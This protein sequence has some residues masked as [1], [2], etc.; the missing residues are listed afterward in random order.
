M[1]KPEAFFAI[2]VSMQDETRER[3]EPGQ[4]EPTSERK[5]RF[6]KRYKYAIIIFIAAILALGS[7]VAYV[8]A[9]SPEV[10]RSP[11]PEHYHFRMQIVVNGSEE[12]FGKDVYQTDYVKNQ[13]SADLPEQPIHFHD[14]KNQFVHIH[15]EGITGGMVM[16]NYGWNY[17]GGMSDALGYRLDDLSDVRKVTLHGDN[18]P[19]AP[20]DA[21]VYVYTGDEQGYEERS[22][23]D[24]K[25]KDL[26]DF[27]GKASNSPTNLLNQ[28][29]SF[30]IF[31]RI[32]PS[33]SAHGAAGGGHGEMDTESE[34]E[35]L[36]RINNLLGN[37][38]IFAQKDRPT[39]Q[40][41]KDRFASLEPLSDSTCGG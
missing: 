15:W 31:D 16:K 21:V 12:D 23:D 9:V 36:T 8:Y 14:N 19:D 3:G 7:C 26:E 37:V 33:V 5:F 20:D 25:S 39:D 17:I 22:F 6:R 29:T 13:C 30:N 35:K 41:V 11:E 1:M 32:F 2:M 4:A 38:V 10:I 34:E 24:W 40:H 27:F 18:L 28:E